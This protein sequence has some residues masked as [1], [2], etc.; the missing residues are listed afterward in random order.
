MQFEDRQIIRRS[1]D[2]DIPF[3]HPVL[4]RTISGTV[5]VAPNRFDAF[6]IQPVPASINQCLENFI[7]RMTDLENEITAVFHLVIGVLIA[8]AASFLL[9]D[10]KRKADAGAIDPTLA[11]LT[12]SPYRHFGA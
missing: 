11:D 2:R 6:Q 9:L 8:E 3:R 1:L 12:P 7:H 5:L 4:A 10:I